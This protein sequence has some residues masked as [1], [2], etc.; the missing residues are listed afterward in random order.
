MIRVL[1]RLSPSDRRKLEAG[2]VEVTGEAKNRTILGIVAG[3]LK[4]YPNI[5]FS[6]LKE[7]LPDH[8]NPKSTNRTTNFFDPYT[9]RPYGVVQPGSIRAEIAE[10]NRLKQAETGAE[11]HYK[12]VHFTGEGETFRTGDGVEVLVANGIEDAHLQRLV[13]HVAQYGVR[14]VEFAPYRGGGKKGFYKVSVLDPALLKKLQ[15]A[16]ASK[17]LIPAVIVG[18]LLLLL[19]AVWFFLRPSGEVATA[20]PPIPV[21]ES[22]RIYG[23][24]IDKVTGEPLTNAEVGLSGDRIGALA[25]TTDENGVYSVEGPTALHAV[26]SITKDGYLAVQ[27][28]VHL[29]VNGT[30]TL[31]QLGTYYLEPYVDRAIL[32]PH[33]EYAKDR[34]ELTPAAKDSLEVFYQ[35][36]VDNPTLVVEVRSHTDARPAPQFRGGNAELSRKRA[37]SCVDYLVSRGID[38]TRLV[39]VGMGSDEPLI[40]MDSI[41]RV[42]SVDDKE[43]LHALNRRSDFRVLD[44]AVATDR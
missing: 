2:V 43:R 33:I 40:P 37:G 20:D 7:M 11:E 17:W 28:E 44:A 42:R 16:E 31:V 23:S 41:M 4:L 8:L 24:I 5:T 30:G 39:A 18:L 19:G 1:Q 29:A 22:M 27:E 36:L 12:M 3:V 25:A 6:E 38:P 13:E 34:Y 15:A 32:L 10:A 9:T 21:Q 14:V 35:V 26:L